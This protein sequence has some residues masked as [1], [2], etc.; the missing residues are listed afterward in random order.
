MWKKKSNNEFEKIR[1]DNGSSVSF[2]HEPLIKSFT[3]IYYV[4]F[5]RYFLFSMLSISDQY[6]PDFTI[7]VFILEITCF[8]FG[9]FCT[10]S[11]RVGRYIFSTKR[12]N[13]QILYADISIKT[14]LLTD[15]TKVKNVLCFSQTLV[16]L[17]TGS[18]HGEC[19]SQFWIAYFST[20]QKWES[21][22]V[23]F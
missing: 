18:A 21:L 11:P 20:W 9:Q 7:Y 3:F 1:T 2:T 16:H 15:L 4:F 10:T 12:T 22:F 13:L 8:I 17:W 19:I 6:Y 23:G 5:F 14:F